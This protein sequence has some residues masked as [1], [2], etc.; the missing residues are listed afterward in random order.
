M[1][2]SVARQSCILAKHVTSKELRL[3]FFWQRHF[4]A[5]N[6]V[7]GKVLEVFGGYL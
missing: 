2:V 1:A 7:I 5:G 6:Y 4:D 3:F